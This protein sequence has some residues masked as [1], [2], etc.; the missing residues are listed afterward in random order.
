MYDVSVDA[1]V[2][3]SVSDEGAGTGFELVE[4]PFV[5]DIVAD[6][7]YEGCLLQ[8]RVGRKAHQ[9]DPRGTA[10]GCQ[11]W[12]LTPAGDGVDFHNHC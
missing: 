8:G 3:G 2:P 1:F 12:P 7:T 9:D 10:G 4:G 6:F 11:A 5:S